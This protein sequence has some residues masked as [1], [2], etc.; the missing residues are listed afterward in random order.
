MSAIAIRKT[1]WQNA[2]DT[3]RVILRWGLDK[4]D[5]GVPVEYRQGSTR[6]FIFHDHR[7]TLEDIARIG[8]LVKGLDVFPNYKFPTRD[9][10]DDSGK[11]LRTVTDKRA[12]KTE[13]VS[14]VRD[15]WVDPSR[16]KVPEGEDA[17]SYVLA[18]QSPPNAIRAAAFV[19]ASWTPVEVA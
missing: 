5:L 3:Q 10:L 2:N 12:T 7:I 19:P 11:V 14:Y 1:A 13:I 6:W 8:V 18:A 16:L 9:I 17:A 15:N 4:L